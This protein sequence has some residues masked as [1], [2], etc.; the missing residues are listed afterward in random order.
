[1]KFLYVNLVLNQAWKCKGDNISVRKDANQE[2]LDN[3]QEGN[4]FRDRAF[5]FVVK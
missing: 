1:M 4:K 2:R 5:N 3:F